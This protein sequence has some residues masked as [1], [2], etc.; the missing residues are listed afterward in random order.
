MTHHLSE[1]GLFD[2]YF[3]E[4]NGDGLAP[5]AAD[6]LADCRRCSDEYSQ[7][8]AFMDGTRATAEAE[9]A[10][11]FTPDQLRLQQDQIRQRLEL[12]GH[13]A[14]VLSFPFGP[15]GRST[16]SF[17]KRPDAFSPFVS[18]MTTRWIAAAAA[19]GL[20]IGVGAGVLFDERARSGPVTSASIAIVHPGASE[21]AAIAPTPT[22]AAPALA[23]SEPVAADDPSSDDTLFMSEL[24]T[25]LGRPHTPELRAL[26]AFTPY[27]RE[28]T[29]RIR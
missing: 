12:L 1:H 13:G 5:P 20:F 6:H 25:A 9:V 4:R 11:V 3:A 19:A 29:Y 28:I 18:R 16:M 26:D 27:A 2:C 15:D 14:R 7:L 21:K 22:E 24:E 8:A 10:E 17:E 23:E